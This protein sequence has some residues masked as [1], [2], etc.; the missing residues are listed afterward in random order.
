MYQTH[1]SH[2]S[3]IHL[4][5][6][7]LLVLLVSSSITH[8]TKT[9]GTVVT[10]PHK[11]G[12]TSDDQP[13]LRIPRNSQSDPRVLAFESAYNSFIE[14]ILTEKSICDTCSKKMLTLQE[15]Y[16]SLSKIT[17]SGSDQDSKIDKTILA[18]TKSLFFNAVDLYQDTGN[19]RSKFADLISCESL[20]NL[21]LFL[22]FSLSHL[23]LQNVKIMTITVDSRMFTG[24]L[25]FA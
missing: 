23:V 14:C 13:I 25:M 5:L 3:F 7:T 1:W 16:H 19:C 8:A 17:S 20:F 6:R 2:Q 24:D 10:F 15:N 21:F 12:E 11:N 4:A 22:L 9:A 18:I